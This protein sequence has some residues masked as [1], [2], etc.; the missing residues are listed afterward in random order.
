MSDQARQPTDF[1]RELRE[2]VGALP[3]GPVLAHTDVFRT[4][5]AVEKSSNAAELLG[6]HVALLERVADGRQLVFPTF[7]YDFTKTGRYS[8]DDDASQ[9]GALSD[10][11][12]RD[13]SS[14]RT[15]TPVF[16]FC[17]RGESLDPVVADATESMDP[18]GPNS[19]FG[20][21]ADADGT[22]ILYGV[23][24][25]RFTAVHYAE[26]CAGRPVYRY[27]KTFPG[28]ILDRRYPPRAVSLLYHVRPLGRG[29]EYD[30]ARL[31]QDALSRGHAVRVAAPGAT[32]IVVRLADLVRY[33]TSR[34]DE[35][36]LF[37]LD[38][39]TRAW[40]E[41]K[42]RELGRRFHLEDFEA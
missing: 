16:N 41:P 18:F 7:N 21:I 40:V 5:G 35:D 36:P 38:G 11:A 33:W 3:A 30:W 9:V 26:V 6:R 29:L 39:P 37:L 34:L 22:V 15:R 28:E 17:G 23:G 20:R 14:W 13:W 31:E 12:R 24:F 19:V 2:V 42:F 32:A 27:D 1:E 4:L 10:F 8:V 25:D